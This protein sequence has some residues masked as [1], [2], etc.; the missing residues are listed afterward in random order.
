MASSCSWPLMGTS[1]RYQPV[2]PSL[3]FALLL[4]RVC[5]ISRFPATVRCA[6]M[7]WWD[8]PGKLPSHFPMLVY[9]S[10]LAP[11]IFHQCMVGVHR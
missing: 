8:D 1:P 6:T 4:V 7:D 5:T 3:K 9:Q 10:C 11:R 2:T